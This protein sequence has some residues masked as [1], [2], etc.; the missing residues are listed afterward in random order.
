M[1][2]LKDFILEWINID[3]IMSNLDKFFNINF[4]MLAFLITALSILQ[5]IKGGRIDEFKECD[6][7]RGV[8]SI[9]TKAFTWNLVAGVA[10]CAVSF[11]NVSDHLAKIILSFF[12]VSLFFTAIYKAYAAYKFLAYFIRMQ[13]PP[14]G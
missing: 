12:S 9:F 10:I 1:Q 7:F 4:V 14:I 8:I 6:L 11:V 5:T 13:N 3:G 2:W